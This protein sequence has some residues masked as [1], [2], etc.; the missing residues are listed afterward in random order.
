[1]RII[2]LKIQLVPKSILTKPSNKNNSI[3]SYQ[4]RHK[5]ILKQKYFEQKLK[6]GIVKQ[7]RASQITFLNKEELNLILEIV[8]INTDR[9]IISRLNIKKLSTIAKNSS[10]TLTEVRV[11]WNELKINLNCFNNIRSFVDSESSKHLVEDFKKSSCLNKM[12]M[13]YRVIG[14]IPSFSSLVLVMRQIL[15][16]VKISPE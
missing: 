4:F 9:K 7:E 12:E 5:I 14:Y 16:F 3:S 15:P 2:S 1:M 8:S 13:R 11:N 6:R 10:K